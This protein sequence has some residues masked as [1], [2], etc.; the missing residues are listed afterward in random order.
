MDCVLF[1]SKKCKFGRDLV[2]TDILPKIFEIEQSTELKLYCT[3]L[4]RA[5]AEDRILQEGI[6]MHK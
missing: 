1:S 5:I 3:A 6:T 4:T 2:I